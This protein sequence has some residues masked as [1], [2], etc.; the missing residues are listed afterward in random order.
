[1][2]PSVDRRKF[3]KAASTTAATFTILQA[4]SAK[5]DAANEKLSIACIGAGGRGAI[6]IRDTRTENIVALC[7]V[8]FQRVSDSFKKHEGLEIPSAT[9]YKDYRVMLSELE[10]KIDAVI[11]STPDHSHFHASM[12]AIGFGKHVYCEKPL[13]HSIWEARE[14]TKAAREAG[15]ATQMGNQ[16][17]ADKETRHRPRIR[18]GQCDRTR[19]AQHTF[20][21]IDPREVCLANTGLRELLA[22]YRYSA[23]TED[24]GLGLVDRSGANATRIILTTHR[25]NGEAAGTLAPARWGTWDVT[26]SIPSIEP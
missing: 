10:S 18:N 22:T 13:T 5:T 19:F 8:D 26:T 23:D 2:P 6:N 20:G 1:M 9:R 3:L 7:D 4:G 16:A 17:Q 21:R 24:I 15:V 12:A 11:V 25:S 14:L